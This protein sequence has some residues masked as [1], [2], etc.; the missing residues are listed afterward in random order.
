MLG[1]SLILGNDLA[2]KEVF[3]PPIVTDHPVPPEQA[4]P[5]DSKLRASVYPAC[6]VTRAQSR[7]LDC[8][9]LSE[10]FMIHSPDGVELEMVALGAVE[11][12]SGEG[13]FARKAWT[14]TQQNRQTKQ[15]QTIKKQ[16][17]SAVDRSSDELE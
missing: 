16:D 1:V 9:N 14:T 17:E 5:S 3:P 13:N 11:S 8:I 12:E 2:A 6:V 7:K 10:T 4:E 15:K